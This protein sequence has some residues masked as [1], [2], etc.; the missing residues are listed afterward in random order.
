MSAVPTADIGRSTTNLNEESAALVE[1]VIRGMH[2]GPATAQLEALAGQGLAMLKGPLAM[3]TPAGTELAG[4]MLRLPAGSAQEQQV[5]ALY[6]TFLPANRRLRDVCTAWQCRPD[7]GPNDHSDPAYDTVVRDDLDDVHEAVAAV[8]RRLAAALPR[9][10]RYLERLEEALERLDD[11]DN[12]WLT[13]PLID[14]YHTVWMQLHQELL[15][16]LGISRAEDAELEERLITAK[17]A[18]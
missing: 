4:R 18:D 15:L 8:L 10:E 1:L 13:A 3:P 9:T 17:D 11:G 2:R 7:G 6:E 12:S 16:S 5:R 14:S